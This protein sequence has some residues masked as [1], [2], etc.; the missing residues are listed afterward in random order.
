MAISSSVFSSSFFTTAL[1]PGFSWKNLHRERRPPV[2]LTI[3]KINLNLLNY[4]PFSCSCSSFAS[5]PLAHSPLNPP[6]SSL[7]HPSQY[8]PPSLINTSPLLSHALSS[9][10]PSSLRSP[11]NILP[12][13]IPPSFPSHNTQEQPVP[14]QALPLLRIFVKIMF[15]ALRMIC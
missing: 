10:C 14:S 12:F 7:P 13:P 2:T 4:H 9:S 11:S 8:F 6:P 5:Y 1:Q 3:H 15:G